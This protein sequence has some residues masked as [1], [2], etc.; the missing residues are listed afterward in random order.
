MQRRVRIVR[1]RAGHRLAACDVMKLERFDQSRAG[2]REEFGEFLGR[3]RQGAQPSIDAAVAA[4]VEDVRERGGKAVAEHTLKFDSLEINERSLGAERFDLAGLAEACPSD[5]R[6]SID[7]AAERIEAYHK[8]HFPHDGRAEDAGGIALSWR[9]SPVDSVGVYVPGGRASYPSTV[10]MNVVPA[11]VAGVGRVVMVSPARDGA[12]SPAVAYA[13]V[14]AGVDQF[15]PIGGAQGVAALALGAGE[16]APV[17]KIVGPGNA[18]VAAAKR[19]VFGLVGIDSIAGPSELTVVAGEENSADWIA[20]DLLSQAEHD[21]L[22]QSILVTDSPGL[23]DRVE[24]ALKTFVL[25]LGAES[26]ASASLATYGAIV[27][28]ERSAAAD[29]V[30]QI[31]PEH[32]EVC[33]DEPQRVVDGIRHAGAIFVGAWACEALGDYVTGSNHVLPTSGAA[34][35]SSGLSTSDFMKRTSVQVVTREGFDHL[36]VSAETLAMNE[37]LPAH[38][39]SVRLR[40]ERR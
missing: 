29:V 39:L 13:A 10:L 32:V 31:A 21:P 38:A 4:I 26:A 24:A 14:R 3:R 40:R 37:G 23:A 11:K 28:C 17:D 8:Q 25:E 9:W 36:S 15:Y 27:L 16:L 33:I 1:P 18:Y 35:F 30:N 7:H 20:A 2:F 34:R 6:A 19:M 12:V 22:A 5:V